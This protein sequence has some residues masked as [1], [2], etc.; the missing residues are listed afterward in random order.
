MFAVAEGLG[1]KG[2]FVTP[3]SEPPGI[4]LGMLTLAHV[5]IVEEYLI[6][7]NFAVEMVRTGKLTAGSRDVSYGG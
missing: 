1:E 4:H 3:M 5:P 2:W 6:D 7:L